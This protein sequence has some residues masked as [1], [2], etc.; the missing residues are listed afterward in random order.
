MSVRR[1]EPELP[2]GQRSIRPRSPAE[3]LEPSRAPARPKGRRRRK[4]SGAFSRWIRFFSSLLTGVFLLLGVLGAGGFVVQSQFADAG[5]LL[6]DRTIIIPRGEGRLEIAER[7][8]KEGII[9][10]RWIFI[11][12]HLVRSALNG[13]RLD[14]KA[15]EFHVGAH[16][17]MEDVLGTLVEGKSVQYKITVPEGLTSQQVVARLQADEN[18]TGEISTIPLEGSLLPDTYPYSRGADRQSVLDRM[19][20]AQKEFLNGLWEKRQEGLAINSIEEAIILAS[21]VEKETAVA[22][23]RALTA[24]VFMNRLHKGMRLQSDPTII[25]GIV[26]GQGSLGRPILKS[27]IQAKSPYNTY[28]INGL[29]PTAICNPGREAILAV[30][31]P[32]ATKALYFVANGTGGHTFSET[33]AAHNAAVA[34][35]RKIEREGLKQAA[36]NAAASPVVTVPSEPAGGGAAPEPVAV[37]AG[38]AA[39]EVAVAGQ[40]PVAVPQTQSVPAPGDGQV[41]S[42]IPLPQRKPR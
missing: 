13:D 37:A 40:D 21:I 15:G 18:L 9:A 4:E 38:E 25:Y 3:M 27:D 19:V 32:A 30:L 34:E 20:E 7:L 39:P 36:E 2:G 14:M 33:L 23:E 6:E 16:A 8:E 22:E 1:F 41:S 17:S 11:V 42:D 5:P 12:N 26:G 31:N 35:W 10:N 28:T 29:P 24:A